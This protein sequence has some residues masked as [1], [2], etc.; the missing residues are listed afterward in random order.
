MSTPPT[1][2]IYLPYFGN[3][4]R[5]LGLL[6]KLVAQL[7]AVKTKFPIV[8]LTDDV[9]AVPQELISLRLGIRYLTRH[10]ARLG[11]QGFAFD[12]KA[13]LVL[14]L[15]HQRLPWGSIVMDLDNEVRCNFD[16]MVEGVPGSFIA[17]PPA[18]GQPYADPIFHP[19]FNKRVPEHT[20][21]FMVF[22]AGDDGAI[23]AK[24]YM[25]LWDLT[26]GEE[27]DHPLREERTWSL[28]WH[29]NT[30]F[31]TAH[32]FP[33]SMSWSRFW[34]EEPKDT[35]IRHKHGAEKWE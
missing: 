29:Y 28:V 34:G 19:N 32:L 13:C 26:Q 21:A 6:L 33:P 4:R 24:S 35:Y 7:Q 16:H 11:H 15:L 17:M 27:M 8:V 3:D 2:T 12:Y 18:P 14:A 31:S 10:Y 1:H 25:S 9:T 30:P 5:Y 23:D 20:S 22:P